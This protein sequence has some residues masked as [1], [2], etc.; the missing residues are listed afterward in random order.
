[1]A[2]RTIDTTLFRT[3]NSV[4]VSTEFDDESPISL[5]LDVPFPNTV[6]D[7]LKKVNSRMY[8]PPDLLGE[9]PGKAAKADRAIGT[10]LAQVLF[11]GLDFRAHLSPIMRSTRNL[12]I[13]VKTSDLELSSLPWESCL[14]ADWRRLG[15]V[16][17]PNCKMAIVRTPTPFTDKWTITKTEKPRILV[18]GASPINNPGTNFSHEIAAIKEGLSKVSSKVDLTPVESTKIQILKGVIEQYKPHIVHLVAHGNKGTVDLEDAEGK[19]VS[20]TG[21]QVAQTF[22]EGINSISLFVSTACL[23]MQDD[24]EKH[25]ASLG[26]TLVH[27]IP[28]ILG[29]QVKISNEQA[30]RFSREFYFGLASSN[31]IF[32]AYIH[33]RD[34]LFDKKPHSPEW[35]GP[36]LYKSG[37]QDPP[38][39]SRLQIEALTLKFANEFRQRLVFMRQDRKDR[40]KWKEVGDLFDNLEE[41][42]IDPVLFGEEKL[43]GK[44]KENWLEIRKKIKPIRELF[45]TVDELLESKSASGNA[46]ASLFDELSMLNELLMDFHDSLKRK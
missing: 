19:S 20:L 41:D 3:G 33:A 21:A 24:F 34:Q 42:L 10:D 9:D 31:N 45:I 46:I 28:Y 43:D 6:T 36:V 35:I 15:I 2:M 8:D 40:R 12:V 38:I 7:W 44:T 16:D 39:F 17:E 25:R 22:S 5:R 29:M 4:A 14:H 13:N 27:Q 1:M 32:E 18:I 23:A 30:V 26:R 37:Y 11:Q